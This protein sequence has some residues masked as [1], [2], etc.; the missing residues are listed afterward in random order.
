MTDVLVLGLG[1]AGRALAHRCAIA[2]LEVRAIDPHPNRRWTPTY[3]AWADE[4]PEWLPDAAIATT[5][6]P[7]AFT[8][9]RHSIAR[10]YCVLSTPKLQA[11]LSLNAVATVEGTVA[12]AARTQVTLADGTVFSA[13]CVIDARGIGRSP[14]AAEQTAFGVV[15]PAETAAP[16]LQGAPA[17]FM[18]WRGDHGASPAAT[19]SFLYAVPL[20][21]NEVLLEET[22]LVGNPALT[23]RE[24]ETR[25]DARLAA[26][27]IT[28]PSAARIERVHF[29]V[30]GPPQKRTAPT[31]FGSRGRLMHPGTGYSVAAS[32]AAADDV[33]EALQ[34]G[35]N[36]RRVLWPTKAHAVQGLRAAGLRTLL[37]LRPDQVAPFFA[38]YFDLP[39]DLQRAYLS[40]RTDLL[41]STKTMLRLFASFPPDLRR[42]AVTRSVLPANHSPIRS[43]STKME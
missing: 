33:A 39:I 8:T 29:P 18:D 3:A 5:V 37:G 35:R 43:Y 13:D 7:H 6:R 11:A 15:V 42:V 34:S 27:G 20:N 21:E 28:R 2:G 26:R 31:A 36:P 22:C 23:L 12:E 10:D 1:P 24:L 14:G 19:P 9:R 17:W 40:R 4:L 41:G 38:T 30:A 25:L 16:A 32:L